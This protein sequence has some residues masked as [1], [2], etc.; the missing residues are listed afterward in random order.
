MILLQGRPLAPIY[1]LLF[2]A[3]L[4]GEVALLARRRATAGV[5]PADRGF[6]GRALIVVLLANVAAIVALKIFRVATFATFFTACTGLVLMGLGLLLRWW[7]VARLERLFTVDVA[8]TAGQIVVA[9]GPYRWIRHPSYTGILLLVT[10]IGV[11]FGNLVSMLVIL[12]PVC[13]LMARRI[14]VEE[15]AL[16][17]ALGDTY[18]DYMA[19]TKRLIPAIY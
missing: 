7:S 12:I 16:V 3:W 9:S 8:V 15:A 10:G 2:G 13:A 4:F 19:R 1:L 11:C 5:A 6:V 17:G 14:R 18:R